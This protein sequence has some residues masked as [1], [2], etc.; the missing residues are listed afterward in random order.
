M[1]AQ[2]SVGQ[3][4]LV[5]Q[6]VCVC[7]SRLFEQS[8]VRFIRVQHILCSP[9]KKITRWTYR[10]STLSGFLAVSLVTILL[11][12]VWQS[13]SLSVGGVLLFAF[14]ERAFSFS[15]MHILLASSVLFKIFHIKLLAHF[16]IG[17]FKNVILYFQVFQPFWVSFSGGE[18]EKRHLIPFWLSVDSASFSSPYPA[19]E[20]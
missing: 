10:L 7:N 11:R 8:D 18:N 17:V 14:S 5:V 6:Y 4:L 20:G 19:E 2:N 13:L 16:L 12:R 3:F 9:E 15:H 1:A